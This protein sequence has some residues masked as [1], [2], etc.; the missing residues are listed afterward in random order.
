MI[1][2]WIS[3]SSLSFSSVRKKVKHVELCFFSEQH[4]LSYVLPEK[5]RSDVAKKRQENKQTKNQHTQPGSQKEIWEGQG[6]DQYAWG[7]HLL[8]AWPAPVSCHST[9]SLG[10]LQ[11][12]KKQNYH[13][14]KFNDASHQG[15]L[16]AKTVEIRPEYNIKERKL[17]LPFCNITRCDLTEWVCK[18]SNNTKG[19]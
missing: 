3:F 13:V 8:T 19:G 18:G 12:T 4:S 9:F 16:N 11:K 6:Q 10:S 2:K 15:Y 7:L 5:S 17:L 1:G 14:A